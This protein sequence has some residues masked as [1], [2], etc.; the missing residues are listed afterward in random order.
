MQ[1]VPSLRSRASGVLLH[2]S[3][4][5]GPAGIGDLGAPAA[6][7]AQSLAEAKQTW[8]QMLPVGPTGFGNS[9]YSAL[10]SFAGNPLLVSLERL[11][12]DGWL[13]G[14]DTAPSAAW[15]TDRVPFAEVEPFKTERLRRAFATFERGASAADREAFESFRRSTGWLADWSLYR[16][17]KDA[18][19]GSDWGSWAPG[20]RAREADALEAARTRLAPEIRYH[21][22]VQYAFARQ[23]DA[24]HARCRELGIGL[25]GDV[26]FYVPYDSAEVWAQQDQFD[27]G[28]RGR[29]MRVAGVPPDDFAKD[30]QLWGFPLYNWDRMRALDYAWW[31]SRFRTTL[32]RFDAVRIDHFIGFHRAWAVPSRLK[33]A[34][35]GRWIQGPGGAVFERLKRVSGS[36]ELIAEDLG[37]VTP[38]VEKLRDD[39]D[40]PGIRVLQFGFG[41]DPAQ[42]HLPHKYPKRSLAATGTHDNDTSRGWYEAIDH[43]GTR[44]WVHRYLKT[45]GTDIAWVM[46]RAVLDSPADTAIVPVQ[47]LLNLGS[48]ARMN[49]PG[50]ATGNWSWRMSAGALTP[51][52][53]HRLGTL[54]HESR[55]ARA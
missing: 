38:E 16:S 26:P 5:P 37:V 28:R 12:E 51:E 55:R 54:T 13:N 42:T 2:P 17:L 44:D 14:A 49:R 52:I 30:G 29:P 15:P 50:V 3:S 24:L 18:H 43:P 20:V 36:L 9:P 27:L 35:R 33:T 45:D 48:E 4:L 22:F 32:A 34:L 6:R 25:I 8:W 19:Q 47:D 40:L 21:D 53:L 1:P 46:I 7:F 11:A 10:S 31:M 41:W 39:F 23:W